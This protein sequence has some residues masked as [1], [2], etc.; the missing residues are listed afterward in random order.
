MSMALC[1]WILFL[2]WVVWMGSDYY[3]TRNPRE[4][5]AGIVV[6]L[7]FLLLGWKVFGSPIHP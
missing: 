6:L 7:L 5:G 3:K 2:I 4:L 1:Y